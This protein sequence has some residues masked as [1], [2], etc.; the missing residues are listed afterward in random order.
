MHER[1]LYITGRQIKQTFCTT[2]HRGADVYKE[3]SFV[4]EAIRGFVLPLLCRFVNVMYPL[5][6]CRVVSARGKVIMLSDNGTK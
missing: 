1:G 3:C 2:P 4:P 5:T 6:Y